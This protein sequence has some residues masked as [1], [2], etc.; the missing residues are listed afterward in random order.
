M[1]NNPPILDQARARGEEEGVGG[2]EEEA[3]GV[4]EQ[5]SQLCLR[6]NLV[7]PT[8]FENNFVEANFV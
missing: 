5:A 7:E 6:T 3:G 2:E 4:Q 8:L 1:F